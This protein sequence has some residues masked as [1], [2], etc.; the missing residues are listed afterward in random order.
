MRRA[1]ATFAAPAV[2]TSGKSIRMPLE[3]ALEKPLEEQ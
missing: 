3:K 1:R 2:R